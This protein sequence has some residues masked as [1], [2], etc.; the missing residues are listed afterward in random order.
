MMQD[1]NKNKTF[2]HTIFYYKRQANGTMGH[3]LTRLSFAIC[4]K[5]Y[6]I[7]NKWIF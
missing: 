2:V 4:Q 1:K 6:T 3:D 7:K 5:L